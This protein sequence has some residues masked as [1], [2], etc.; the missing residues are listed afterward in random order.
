MIAVA[1]R[2]EVALEPRPGAGLTSAATSHLGPRGLIQVE[3]A[4][5][6]DAASRGLKDDAGL[7]LT[8]TIPTGS[9]AEVLLPGQPAVVVGPGTH[10]FAA[11]TR[12]SAAKPELMRS[13][14]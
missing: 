9:T 4:R 5:S 2:D 1:A 13:T 3:W 11:A 6:A 10:T 14:L 12:G 8:A 7:T